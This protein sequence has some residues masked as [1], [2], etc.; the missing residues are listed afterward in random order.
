MKR[1]EL[2]RIALKFLSKQDAFLPWLCY[3]RKKGG[4]IMKKITFGKFVIGMLV[5]YFVLFI[6]GVFDKI[7]NEM[8]INVVSFICGAPLFI[9][10]I[11]HAIRIALLMGKYGIGAMVGAALLAIGI[12]VNPE[13]L[14]LIGLFVLVISV[15][16]LLAQGNVDP[17]KERKEREIE[18][19]YGIIDFMKNDDDDKNDNDEKEGYGAADFMEDYDDDRYDNL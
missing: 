1:E 17:D 16:L 6:S 9:W 5:L 13:G 11:L 15:I 7:D 10:L 12:A 4:S 2:L 18:R 3:N 19:E 14:G 8:F